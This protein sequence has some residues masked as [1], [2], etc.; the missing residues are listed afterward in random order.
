MRK[1]GY[2][3]AIVLLTT[4]ATAHAEP[5]TPEAA[6]EAVS[7]AMDEIRKQNPAGVLPL[8]DPVVV[9]LQ[10]QQSK[11]ISQCADDMTQA[12]LLS[13]MQAA[14]L[15][16]QDEAKS[17][18]L[19]DNAYCLAPFLKGF[20]LIDLH[21]WD[22]AEPMLRLASESAPL[23]AQFRNEYAEWFKAMKQWQKAHDVFEEAYG[24]GEFE[25][26]EANK[27]ANQARALRGMGF[28]EIEMGDLD[29]AEKSFKKSLK[30]IPNHEGAK[31]EL[32]YIANLRKKGKS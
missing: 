25:S 4:A 24:L 12:I 14:A 26:D 15:K 18:A 30:I 23:N 28:T 31:I 21:R 10:D 5:M 16:K 6:R 1:T 11:Q 27:K 13:A 22:D 7:K 19:I 2:L 3:A 20:A 29:K 8:V 32:Q 9:A 17:A